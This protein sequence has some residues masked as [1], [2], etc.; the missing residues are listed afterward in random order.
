MFIK[1]CYIILILFTFSCSENEKKNNSIAIINGY[2]LSIEE[3][4]TRSEY[5]IRPKF[6]NGNS[7]NDKKI[8]LK[9]LILEKLISQKK[10]ANKKALSTKSNNFIIGRRNQAM[11]QKLFDNIIKNSIK[12]DTN[13]INLNLQIIGREYDLSY[14]QI[15]TTYE[16]INEILASWDSDSNLTEN[17]SNIIIY[18]KKLKWNEHE[19]VEILDSL[20]NF[21]TYKNQ[22]IGP[23]INGSFSMFIKV[24]NWINRPAITDGEIKLRYKRYLDFINKVES[25]ALY[26]EYIK[27]IMKNKDIYFS[28]ENF[29]IIVNYFGSKL[30][31][32]K[33]KI[34]DV[35]LGNNQ[36]ISMFD[37]SPEI[38][39]KDTLFQIAGD[40]WTMEQFFNAI[41]THPLVFRNN[42][43]KKK[44]FPNQ[45]KL[46]I[47]DLVRDVFLTNEALS[48]GLEKD[49]YV[50]NQINIWTDYFNSQSFIKEKFPLAKTSDEWLNNHNFQVEIDELINLYNDEIIINYEALENVSLTTIPFHAVYPKEPYPNVT[51]EILPFTKSNFN[52]NLNLQIQ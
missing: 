6:C 20:Y 9:N 42:K 48:L 18:S 37:D 29:T 21:G 23:F 1:L 52:T 25:E 40:S 4:L 27:K 12:I 30:K 10:T 13:S 8:I 15:P 19:K 41:K 14:I 17:F 49:K 3:F 50:L 44:D 11:R 39:N 26:L 31:I 51:A 47:G 36:L 34:I 38:N 35:K 2:Y 33:N 46:A 24:K 22:I 32:D 28:K 45:L 16:L 5:T 43:I 7:I